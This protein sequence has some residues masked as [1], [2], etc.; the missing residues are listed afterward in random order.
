QAL[1]LPRLLPPRL[2]QA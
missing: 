1:R 2:D